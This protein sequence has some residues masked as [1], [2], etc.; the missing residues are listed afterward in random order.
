MNGIQLGR[1]YLGDKILTERKFRMDETGEIWFHTGD[2]G[3]WMGDNLIIMGRMD[4]QVKLRGFRIELGEIESVMME[5]SYI[6][7]VAVLLCGNPASLVAMVISSLSEECWDGCG[8]LSLRL[9][10]QGVIHS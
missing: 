2:R 7:A 4:T 8:E 9:H 3:R 1:G 5:C 10:C 6:E